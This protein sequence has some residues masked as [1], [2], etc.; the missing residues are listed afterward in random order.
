MRFGWRRNPAVTTDAV[1]S[2][3]AMSYRRRHSPRYRRYFHAS[4]IFLR[5]TFIPIRRAHVWPLCDSDRLRTFDGGF[6]FR[7]RREPRNAFR[8]NLDRPPAPRISHPP[9]LV[10]GHPEGAKSRKRDAVA[11]LQARPNP[12]Q[13]RFQG[14]SGLR[15]G[16]L[17][18]RCNFTDHV[19]FVHEALS[20]PASNIKAGGPV[21]TGILHWHGPG[22]CFILRFGR[23]GAHS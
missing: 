7:P 19:F 5:L 18:I 20:T 1:S 14:A 2:P 6:Q 10:L 23:T 22:N 8:L 15:P 12:R 3:A 11:A 9:G 13:A 21:S 16:D 17:R 4:R